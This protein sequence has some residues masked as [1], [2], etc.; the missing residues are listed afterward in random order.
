MSE[1]YVGYLSQSPPGIRRRVRILVASIL[2]LSLAGAI[3]FAASQKHFANST[4]EFGNTQEFHGIFLQNPYPILIAP[5]D[6]AGSTAA[7]TP[8]LLVASGKHGAGSG[9]QSFL[10]Q[11]IRLK[12]TLISRREGHMIEIVPGSPIAEA[13]DSPPLSGEHDLG[14]RDLSGEIVDSKCFLGVM[15]PG[16]GK[17]H[18]ECAALCLRGGIPPALFT[19][20]LDGSPKI[21]LLTDSSGSP[22]PQSAY[23][24]RV[25]QPV[26]IHGHAVLSNGLYYLRSEAD[27]I[28]ALP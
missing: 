25:G 22:L 1:F 9:L 7:P 11:T 13:R 2:V 27:N 26:R 10:G 5:G 6:T 3:L 14:V 19:R 12:G 20:D 23:L 16:E 17:V 21:L 15:N 18:R 24:Q 28:F 4:F 8:Y